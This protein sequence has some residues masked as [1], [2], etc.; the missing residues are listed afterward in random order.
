MHRIL[1]RKL[2][3]DVPSDV[4]ERSLTFWTTALAAHPRPVTRFPEYH[5]LREAAAPGPVWVQD[6]GEAPARYHVDIETDDVEAEVARLL[7]AGATEMQRQGDWVVMQDPAGLL[8]CVI[9]EEGDGFAE[10]SI[11]VGS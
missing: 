1:L 6:I 7:A 9:P 2:F 8:F 5:L 10:R 3:V 11:V 4:H